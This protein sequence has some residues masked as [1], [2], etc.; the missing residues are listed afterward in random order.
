M[1]ELQKIVL[2]RDSKNILN[3]LWAS[4]RRGELTVLL[5]S[6]GTGKTSLLHS[7]SGILPRVSGDII[8]EGKIVDPASEQWRGQLSYVLDNGGTIP[9]LTVREQIFLQCSLSDIEDEE[10]MMRASHVLDLF[11]L[12]HYRDYRADELSAGLRKKLGIATGIV[13]DAD[14]YLFDEP[15][16]ALDIQSMAVF[17][18][19]LEVLRSRGKII[20]IATHSFQLIASLC[21]RI[22]ELSNGLV[23][24]HSDEAGMK[25][26][27]METT[28]NGP[29]AAGHPIILPWVT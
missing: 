7:I 16:G 23:L 21:D 2:C 19:I 24:E 20:I 22:W 18:R 26:L 9:L 13:R 8:F 15:F 12:N 1:L 10:A 27:G 6:N 3:G 28:V 14:I 5:G 25:K 29:S 4:A 11:E 17:S